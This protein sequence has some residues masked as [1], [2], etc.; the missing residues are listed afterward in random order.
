MSRNEG[1][2]LWLPEDAGTL[3]QYAGG[4]R[5]SRLS[6]RERTCP[7]SGII[8]EEL[9]SCGIMGAK[10]STSADPPLAPEPTTPSRE[11]HSSQG[12]NSFQQTGQH[13]GAVPR[14]PQ[15]PQSRD[16]TSDT[17]PSLDYIFADLHRRASLDSAT[18]SSASRRARSFT[19][20]VVENGPGNSNGNAG[21]PGSTTHAL[22]APSGPEATFL[23][24]S[25]QS[26]PLHFMSFNSKYAHLDYTHL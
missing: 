10:A 25:A 23:A 12:S 3:V 4:L 6:V 1:R 11:S 18:S 14:S 8:A 26:L 21:R 2:C 7:A 16:G 17:V 9:T 15:S 5:T 13:G 24:E 19:G 20:L 22:E